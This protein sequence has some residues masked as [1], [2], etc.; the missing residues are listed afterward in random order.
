MSESF[1]AVQVA[2]ACGVS[3]RQVDYWIRRGYVQLESPAPG[4]GHPRQ[5]TFH[6]AL[7]VKVFAAA[8][9]A[10]LRCREV[11]VDELIGSGQQELDWSVFSLPVPRLAEELRVS[12]TGS[13]VA[14]A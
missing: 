1:S 10:G 3:Y 8:A 9:A 11:R 6:E 13:E 5:L 14:G 7:R 2:K 4:W 12:L